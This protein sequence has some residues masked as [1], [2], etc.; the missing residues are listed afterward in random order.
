ML[1][2]GAREY[3]VKPVVR[4]EVLR[5]TMGI[6]NDIDVCPWIKI[7]TDVLSLVK[8][9]ASDGWAADFTA[10]DLEDPHSWFVRQRKHVFVPF[11]MR[12]AGRCGHI[13]RDPSVVKDRLNRSQ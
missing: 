9:L 12:E 4:F 6:P 13:R 7:K 5:K 3:K 8:I 11:R 10:P 2:A 1:K